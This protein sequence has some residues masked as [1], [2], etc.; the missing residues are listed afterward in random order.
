M[1][2]IISNQTRALV[3]LP[4]DCKPINY[5]W[6]FRRKLRPDGIV[7]KIKVKLVAKGCGEKKDFDYFDPP[8]L[9]EY[10]QSNY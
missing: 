5:K 8:L 10:L 1:H 6:V 9:R 2:S 3:D 7:K 4:Q